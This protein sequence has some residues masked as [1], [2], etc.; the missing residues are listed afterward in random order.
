[1]ASGSV[2]SAFAA[3]ALKELEL[4]KSGVASS[5]LSS[6]SERSD[7]NESGELKINVSLS[8]EQI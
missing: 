6:T 8:R 7:G 3:R 4:S 2:L 1:M 5:I